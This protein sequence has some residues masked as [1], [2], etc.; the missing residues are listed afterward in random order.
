[1]G[2]VSKWTSSIIGQ[3]GNFRKAAVEDGLWDYLFTR[4]PNSLLVHS[5]H[6]TSK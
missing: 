4:L 2:G 6:W 1:M 5:K 3:S